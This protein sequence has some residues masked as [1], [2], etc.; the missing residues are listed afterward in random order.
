MA[1]NTSQTYLIQGERIQNIYI[2]S[3]I[4]LWWMSAHGDIK[5]PYLYPARERENLQSNVYV[6]TY[7]FTWK[8][9]QW[10]GKGRNKVQILILQILIDFFCKL[11]DHS[12]L[13]YFV[14]H[15]ILV[16]R[17]LH[18]FPVHHVSCFTTHFTLDYEANNENYLF[19]HIPSVFFLLSF[20]YAC[21]E[22]LNLG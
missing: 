18:F 10:D 1:Q 11:Y 8:Q 2:P 5:S 3:T 6:Y 13:F 20:L 14:P 22:N 15:I 16:H 9:R 7:S 21:L 4:S 12:S 17:H 19:M